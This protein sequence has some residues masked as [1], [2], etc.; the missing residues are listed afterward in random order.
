MMLITP[1][2]ILVI[3]VLKPCVP[4]CRL[5]A[6]ADNSFIVPLVGLIWKADGDAKE[7][8][9]QMVMTLILLPVCG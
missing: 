3:G 5:H 8:I 2:D 7:I 9:C 4:I 1:G 6:C